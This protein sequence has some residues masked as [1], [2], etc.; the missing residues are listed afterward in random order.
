MMRAV[1]D[2]EQT[3]WNRVARLWR[4]TGGKLRREA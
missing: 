2:V 4:E 1:V 3:R